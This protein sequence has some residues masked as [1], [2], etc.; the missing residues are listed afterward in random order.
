VSP[1]KAYILGLS[2]EDAKSIVREQADASDA[3][4]TRRVALEIAERFNVSLSDATISVRSIVFEMAAKRWA[5][6]EIRPQ[7]LAALHRRAG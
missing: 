7:N 4:T 5:G 6:V 1:I 3:R 2:D